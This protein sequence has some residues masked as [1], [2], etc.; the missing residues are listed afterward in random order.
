MGLYRDFVSDTVTLDEKGRLVLPKKVREAAQ[1]GPSTKLVARAKG[2]GAVELCDLGLLVARA[3]EIGARRLA[4]W[5][6][7]D[8]E[9]DALVFE[10]AKR[11][12][13]AH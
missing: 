6:E 2:V 13:E 8:H 9:T 5:R 1:I 3:Q 4:G 11:K 10:L 7:E 12:H